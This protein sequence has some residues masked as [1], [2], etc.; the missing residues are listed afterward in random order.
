ML[1]STGED[2]SALPTADD[3]AEVLLYEEHLEDYY[4]DR[5]VILRLKDRR[6]CRIESK[7]GASGWDWVEVEWL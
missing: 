4:L 2:P 7:S 6:I 1:T 3:I 5:S